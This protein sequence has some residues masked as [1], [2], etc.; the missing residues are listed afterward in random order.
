MRQIVKSSKYNAP[1]SSPDDVNLMYGKIK[2]LSEQDKLTLMRKMFK[3][4]N[5]EFVLFSAEM[6]QNLLALH[7]VDTAKTAF[8]LRVSM[9]S[10]MLWHHYPALMSQNPAGRTNRLKL[11]F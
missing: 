8:Q 5:A 4:K 2:A 6:F 9:R 10:K 1:V 3:L 11:S 7:A